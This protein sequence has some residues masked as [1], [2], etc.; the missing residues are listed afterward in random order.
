VVLFS[1][2][3]YWFLHFPFPP[4]SHLRGARFMV[5][6]KQQGCDPL[7][8]VDLRSASP[9]P[10]ICHTC[11]FESFE[12]LAVFLLNTLP[13]TSSTHT[14]FLASLRSCHRAKPKAFPVFFSPAGDLSPRLLRPSLLPP[15]SPFFSPVELNVPPVETVVCCPRIG[16]LAIF[17]GRVLFFFFRF[18]FG[19]GIS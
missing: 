3:C 15:R 1:N 5:L 11:V 10:G 17:L 6:R 7:F 4:M 14:I 16:V 8:Q 12:M 9:F 13:L 2:H 19:F 18:S